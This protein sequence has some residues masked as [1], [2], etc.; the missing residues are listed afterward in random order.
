MPPAPEIRDAA[1]EIGVDEVLPEADADHGAQAP[2]HVGIAGKIKINLEGKGQDARPVAQEAVLRGAVLKCL[3]QLPAGV[4]QQQFFG[5]A[6]HKQ[7]AAPGEVLPGD[8]GLFQ[9]GA[10]VPVALDGARDQLGKQGD[11][12]AVAQEVPVG[13]DA[14]PVHV[15]AVAHGL[16]GV[17][18]NA[19]RQRHL[20]A[21]NNQPCILEPAKD[22]ELA[23]EG[24]GQ[25]RPFPGGPFCHA[26]GKEV[27]DQDADHHQ[28][29]GA[30][31][32]PGVEGEACQK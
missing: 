6:N 16:E 19:H 2:G 4:C 22:D 7:P 8:G 9:L 3:P 20:N 1:G 18:G 11:E 25:Q 31:L 21:G 30:R 27:V 13:G 14:P 12:G 28:D 17:K 32:P 15:H 10:D 5:Q 23:G 24:Q 29:G 26:Q